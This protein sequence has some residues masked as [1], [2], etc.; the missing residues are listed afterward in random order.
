MNMCTAVGSQLT[1]SSMNLSASK[2]KERKQELPLLLSVEYPHQRG[3]ECVD[4][5]HQS[6]Q[7]LPCF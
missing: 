5:L 4:V 2:L 1:L 6:V 3:R 7:V